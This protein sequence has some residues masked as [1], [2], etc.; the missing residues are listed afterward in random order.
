MFLFKL[1]NINKLLNIITHIININLFIII[2]MCNVTVW[3]L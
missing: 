3:F 1:I 2:I